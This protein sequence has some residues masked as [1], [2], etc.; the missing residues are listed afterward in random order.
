MGVKNNNGYGYINSPMKPKHLVHR[1]MYEMRYGPVPAG[2]IV[3]HICDLPQCVNPEHLRVGT[4][5]DNTQD[6]MR[7]GRHRVVAVRGEAHR[8]AKLTAEQVMNIRARYRGSR[9]ALALE[10][11]VSLSL[12]SMVAHG[13]CWKHLPVNR[14]ARRR[15]PR[16]V[17]LR[18]EGSG[19]ISGSGQ[20]ERDPERRGG[21]REAV[22]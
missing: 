22:D 2:A 8:W 13:R 16:N 18:E 4:M 12:I 7:R 15:R 17:T 10:Y 21:T 19:R 9:Q 1:L 5:K 20:G 3:R 14:P 6:M 11:G